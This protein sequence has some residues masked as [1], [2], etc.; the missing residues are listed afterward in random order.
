MANVMAILQ[1]VDKCIRCNGCVVGCKRT[2][3]M[4]AGPAGVHRVNEYSRVVVKSQKRIDM[5]PFVRF[6]CWHCENPP[7]AGRCPFKAI[8]KMPD[9]A[10]NVDASK[11]NPNACDK[12]C[13]SDC[14]RGGYPKV[15]TGNNAGDLDAYKCVLCSGRAGVGGDLPTKAA[16]SEI[17][18]VPEKA[19]QPT[20]VYTCPA[21]AMTYDTRANI[22]KKL[23]DMQAAATAAGTPFSHLGDGSMF[24]VS[25]KY[26]LV[27]PKADPFIEDHITP[28]VSGALSSPL[29]KAAIVPTLVVGGLMALSARR[30]ENEKEAEYA[31]EGEV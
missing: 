1:E 7:C 9:G 25:T 24:W 30:A 15:G 20:C 26:T 16:Q 22:I 14:Q 28:M 13:V 29:V 5:G 10:V 4:Q 18:A 17:D 12:Q 23:Q 27:P 21:R 3:G 31:M 19:H 2:W 11:C 8:T 6:S